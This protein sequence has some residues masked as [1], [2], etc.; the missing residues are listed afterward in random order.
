LLLRLPLLHARPV[1]IDPAQIPDS[2]A[3]GAVGAGDD[4]AD[5]R[6]RE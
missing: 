3:V 1:G 4:D 2:R 5:S 6:E